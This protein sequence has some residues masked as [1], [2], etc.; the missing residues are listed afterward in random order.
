M[1]GILYQ[2]I[3]LVI[4]VVIGGA[5]IMLCTKMVAGFT[6][7]FMN[8]A[9]AAL[10]VSIAG[11]VVAY[12]L[13]MVLGPG[14]LTGLLCLIIIFLLYAA[15]INAVVKPAGGGQMGFGKAALV[16]LLVIII[17]IVLFVVLFFVF[18][19]ALFAMLGAGIH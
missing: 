2:V 12:L 13:Q 19:A 15:I 9:L 14:G 8:S 18:G 16:T 7:S 3:G 11:G 5:L 17:E 4:G 6:P 10:G 1:D